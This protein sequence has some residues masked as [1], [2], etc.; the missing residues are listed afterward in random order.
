MQILINNERKQT[1]ECIF[2]I[3]SSSEIRDWYGSSSTGG[4]LRFYDFTILQFYH[5]TI[6]HFI[7]FLSTSELLY[8]STSKP[9]KKVT[10]WWKQSNLITDANNFAAPLNI[11]FLRFPNPDPIPDIPRYFLDHWKRQVAENIFF[12]RF[13]PLRVFWMLQRHF[14]GWKNDN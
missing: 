6:N 11:F 10:L 12:L 4:D 2:I 14:L 9:E 8:L 3:F 7:G 13:Q 1:K 5:F